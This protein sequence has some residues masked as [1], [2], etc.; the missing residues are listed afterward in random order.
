MF[1][2]FDMLER[3]L[4]VE[5]VKAGLKRAKAEGKVLGRPRVGAVVETKM[6]ALRKQ[7]LSMRAIA[8]ELRIGNCT[9]Q[10][11]VTI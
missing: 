11:I 6:L 5:R 1:G 7:G 8:R 9:V 4:I 3:S 10:R 2:V